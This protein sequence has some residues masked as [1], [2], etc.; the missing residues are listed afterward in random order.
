MSQKIKPESI[1]RSYRLGNPKKS[2]EAK[3]RPIM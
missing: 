2:I 1:D 3:P